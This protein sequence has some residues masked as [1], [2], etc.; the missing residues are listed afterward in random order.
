MIEIDTIK[1]FFSKK[2]M[3]YPLI[4]FENTLFG[5]KIQK[6]RF[7]KKSKYFNTN[8]FVH[9][10]LRIIKKKLFAECLISRL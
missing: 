1:K 9:V 4:F 3:D 6:R 7:F 8:I 5:K 2:S 10:I